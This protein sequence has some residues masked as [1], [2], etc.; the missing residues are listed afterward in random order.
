MLLKL[1]NI[2]KTIGA[3]ALYNGLDFMVRDGE[4]VGLVGRNGVGKTTL[5]G[6][7]TGTDALFDGDIERRRGL[8]I[9]AT[10]QE[11]FG[12]G[13]RTA[14]HYILDEL[15]DYRSLKTV[16]DTYPETMGENMKL[17]HEY[18]EAL[19]RF[20]ELGYYDIEE[21]VLRE[22]EA[23]GIDKARAN[24]PL[25]NLSGGQKRFAELVKVTMAE[26][27]LALI[28]EPT[29]HMDY[30]AKEA[31]IEWLK[32]TPM[33]VVVVT[34]DRDVLAVVDRVVEIKDKKAFSFPG[35]YDAYLAQNGASTLSQMETYEQGQKRLL[36][37]DKQIAVAKSKKASWSGTADKTNP[38]MLLE[39]RLTKER[40]ELKAN[41]EKPSFWIDREQL[42]QMKPKL[43][44][45]YDKYKARNIRID[46]KSAES[47]RRRLVAV[48]DVS[49][50]YAM[51][52]FAGVNIEL[53]VGERLQLRGR[54]GVGKSTLIRA[55]LAAAGVGKLESKIF[56]G[57]IDVDPRL[58]I[59]IYEQEVD[60]RY[61]DKTLGEAIT[62]VYH[63]AG[64]A[65][66]DEKV[67]QIA[68]S[69]LFDPATD[70]RLPLERLSGGQKARFQI[71]QMLCDD[72]G[73]LILDEPTNHLDLPSIEELEQALGRYTGAVLYVSH[74]SYFA[75][76]VGGET[77]EIKV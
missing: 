40:D 76:N 1:S 74:D 58:R 10:A 19:G 60:A 75:R 43:A 17:I 4:K 69:Y 48:E 28:D 23:F 71:I 31:F 64:V 29:N 53:H 57:V 36:R 68:A 51:P 37:I 30:V 3:K 25:A 27:D 44:E 56:G 54:N 6:V 67:M 15:P 61:L 39:R 12:V 47:G 41:L 45:Q 50:G 35:N 21:R 52:L 34:H 59:G 2:S 11:H 42:E 22:L 66:N 65:V 7:I 8:R 26:A 24:R 16:I 70:V 72:P 32:S 62:E 38:F 13:D 55:I 77:V 49:L 9:V 14:L 20:G 46:M 5:F 73:L 18:T 63:D 33:A